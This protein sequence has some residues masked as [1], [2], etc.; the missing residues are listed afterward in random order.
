MIELGAKILVTEHALERARERLGWE[1]DGHLEQ[2]IRV[3]VRV[4]LLLD[5]VTGVRPNWTR[6][7]T[8]D[9]IAGHAGHSYAWDG[10]AT[11]C[12]ILD[13]RDGLPVYVRSVLIGTDVQA[14]RSD[15]R[16]LR[17]RRRPE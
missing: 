1:D 5:R 12:W 4:A 15:T 6:G 3:D 14:E 9:E 11:R 17:R 8:L 7:A 10:D 13:I 16:H 2:R